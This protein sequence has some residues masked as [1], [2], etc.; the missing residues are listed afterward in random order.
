MGQN[1]VEKM[2]EKGVNSRLVKG[3]LEKETVKAAESIGANLVIV[4]REQKKKN[5]L[6][7]PVKNVKRK[8]A[9]KCKYSILFIN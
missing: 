4:G 8:I 5:I 2:R 7:L 3:S 6:G 1:F 9:E